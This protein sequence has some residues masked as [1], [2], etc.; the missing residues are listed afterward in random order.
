MSRPNVGFIISRALVFVVWDGETEP[1]AGDPSHR[2]AGWV[3]DGG[4]GLS[5]GDSLHGG[6]VT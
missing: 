3:V 6:G 1:N 4:A 2:E 5:T